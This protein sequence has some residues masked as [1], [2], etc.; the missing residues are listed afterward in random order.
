MRLDSQVHFVSSYG[1]TD[2]PSFPLP[3]ILDVFGEHCGFLISDN[4]LR[5]HTELRQ[6]DSIMELLPFSAV[7]QTSLSSPEWY[8]ICWIDMMH[9]IGQDDLR[10]EWFHHMSTLVLWNDI[11]YFGHKNHTFGHTRFS[12]RFFSLKMVDSEKVALEYCFSMKNK[13][14]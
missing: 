5:M 10:T 1:A 4:L 12:T 2:A 14:D 9:D 13:F 8:T 3:G 11:F 7:A 6:L